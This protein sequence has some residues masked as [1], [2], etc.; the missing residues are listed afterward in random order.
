MADADTSRTGPLQELERALGYVFRD[1][2]LLRTAL[3]HPT[4]AYENP[5]EAAEDN[6]RLEFLGDAVFSLTVAKTLQ[7]WPD[8]LPEGEMTRIRA[9]LVSE[10]T[11]AALA[12]RIGLGALLRFGRGEEGT[13][14]RDRVSNLSNALEAVLGAVFLDGGFEA[15]EAVVLRLYGD[16]IAGAV[17]DRHAL[18]A[19]S[20]LLEIVQAGTVRRKASFRIV[21]EEG[22]AHARRYAAEALVDGAVVGAGEGASKQEAEQEAA[23]A[24]VAALAAGNGAAQAEPDR[25]L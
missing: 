21:R 5:S 7:S 16:R 25:M 24:A 20:R 3:V 4:F 12:R 17:R 14:G 2:A 23:S 1:P 11:Q 18:D 22:P 15:A 10:R 8:R 9:L 6:E 19:K 13:G